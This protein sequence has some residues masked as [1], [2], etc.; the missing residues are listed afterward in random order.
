LIELKF[1][2]GE[3]AKESP[4]TPSGRGAAVTT[5]AATNGASKTAQRIAGIMALTSLEIASGFS[6]R[7]GSGADT[8]YKATCAPVVGGSS[9]EN[10]VNPYERILYVIFD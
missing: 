7:S 9:E 4:A 3:R 5:T 6:R 1:C 10:A 2:P 8:M